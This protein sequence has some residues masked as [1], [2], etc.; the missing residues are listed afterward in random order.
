MKYA[1]SSKPNNVSSESTSAHFAERI[2]TTIVPASQLFRR[3]NRYL[4]NV[5]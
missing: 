2:A 3:L 5:G 1:V 4:N